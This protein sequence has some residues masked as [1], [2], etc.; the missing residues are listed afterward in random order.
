[1]LWGLRAGAT[2]Q[3]LVNLTEESFGFFVCH[4]DLRLQAV[5]LFSCVLSGE[6]SQTLEYNIGFEIGLL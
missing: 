3:G 2:E 4:A 6:G 5:G 1:M